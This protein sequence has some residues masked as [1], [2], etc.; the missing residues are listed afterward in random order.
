MAELREEWS[1]KINDLHLLLVEID[2]KESSCLKTCESCLVRGPT[3]VI[4]QDKDGREKDEKG[5][6]DPTT[7]VRREVEEVLDAESDAFNAVDVGTKIKSVPKDD[8]DDA[9][10]AGD[11]VSVTKESKNIQ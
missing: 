8:S 3:L 1:E 10:D 11:L 7:F 5:E 9:Y 4:N 6:N 2:E